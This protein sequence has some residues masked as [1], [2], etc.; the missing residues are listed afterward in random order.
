MMSWMWNKFIIGF[1]VGFILAT[2][3]VSGF[4]MMKPPRFTEPLDSNQISRLNDI[5]EDM[6]NIT[7][8]RYSAEI[9]T[10]VPASTNATEGSIKV[11]YSGSTHR[12]YWFADS[13]WHHCDAD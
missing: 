10:S 9:I 1:I 12:I 4:R 11:Y 13:S 5:L 3:T 2:T 7:T 8:G 6:W